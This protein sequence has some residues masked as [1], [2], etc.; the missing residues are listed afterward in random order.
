M[1]VAF[2]ALAVAIGGTSY[3][4][5]RLPPKSVGTAQ[6]K[7]GAVTRATIRANA[8]GGAKVADDSLTGDDINE[9]TL[10]DVIASGLGRA[11]YE[12]ATANLPPAVALDAPSVGSASAP[13]DEGQ[14]AVA[15]GARVDAPDAGEL[16]ASFPDAGGAAWTVYV[17]NG[18]LTSAHGFTA[19]AVCVSSASRSRR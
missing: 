1:V 12:T 7:T 8:V 13:C 18:D 4:I 16:L 10:E 11:F 2:A 15:G 3:A 9:S 19:F 6:L 17:A 14:R 5:V